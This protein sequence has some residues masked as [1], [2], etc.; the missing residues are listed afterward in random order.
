MIQYGLISRVDAGVIEKTVDL[1]CSEFKDGIIN[2]TEVGV[3]AGDTGRGICEYIK[4]KGKYHY[5][6]G[7]D[8]SKDGE[9]I[10]FMYNDLIKGNS[11]EV[12]NQL[13]DESQ[14]LIFV[15]ANHSLPST[16]TDFFCYESKVKVGGYFCFHDVG[17]HIKR[18]TDYQRMGDKG[19]PDMYISCRRALDKIGVLGDCLYGWRLVFDEADINDPAGGVVVFKKYANI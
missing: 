2:I 1:I 19:D 11:N 7:I 9:H 5:I 3:Y 17:A 13:K 15:D 8:N 4:S 14:H 6:T 16:I 10:R 12:Y 18:F